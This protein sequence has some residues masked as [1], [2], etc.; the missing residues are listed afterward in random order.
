MINVLARHE[1]AYDGTPR[2]VIEAGGAQAVAGLNWQS[3]AFAEVFVRTDP[4]LRGRGLGTSAVAGVTQAV[5]AG[6]RTPLYLVEEEQRTVAAYRRG[7]R[8]CGHRRASGVRGCS[9]CGAGGVGG[10]RA[11]PRCPCGC[12]PPV[13]DG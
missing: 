7:P 4:P 6:G 1:T 3:P 10:C 13:A 11:D 2:C 9:L 5:L 12:H 8:L